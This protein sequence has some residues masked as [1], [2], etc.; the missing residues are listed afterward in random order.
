MEYIR[1][2]HPKNFDQKRGVFGELAF[3]KSSTDGGASVLGL[4]C[5]EGRNVTPCDHIRGLYPSVAGE[6]PVFWI[7]REEVLPPGYRI[8][9][10]GTDPCHHNIRDVSNTQ[11]GKIIAKVP[12]AEI[13]IC[14]NG[15]HRPLTIGDLEAIC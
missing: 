5:I 10:E 3:K 4:R 6:P 7:F 13:S 2:L 11:L 8:P 1:L 14:N 12:I 15:D 9:Q